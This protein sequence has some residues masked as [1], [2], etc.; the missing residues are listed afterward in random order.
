MTKLVLFQERRNDLTYKLIN[1]IQP[2]NTNKDTYHIIMSTHVGKGVT[3]SN[4][5][6]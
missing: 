6:S 5:P 4:N 1:V 2:I 3:K